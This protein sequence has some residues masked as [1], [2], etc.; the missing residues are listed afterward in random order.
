[1]RPERAAVVG[2]SDEGEA[3]LEELKRLLETAGGVAVAEVV[4]RRS[5]RDAA[6]LIGRGKA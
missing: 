1:M 3:A 4:K 6:T 2:F 5:E